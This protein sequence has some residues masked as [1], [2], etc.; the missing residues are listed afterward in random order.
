MNFHNERV[1]QKLKTTTL[2]SGALNSELINFHMTS[3]VSGQD[4]PNLEL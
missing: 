2:A 4:K 1:A 3:S